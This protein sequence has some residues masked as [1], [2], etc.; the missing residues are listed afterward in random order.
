MA[1]TGADGQFSL[2]SVEPGEY[3]LVTAM[4]L[5]REPASRPVTL[6]EGQALDV[7][8][9]PVRPRP[10]IPGTIGAELVPDDDG[11]LLIVGVMPG[12]PA[13][14]AGLLEGDVLLSVDGAP[15]TG[16]KQAMLRLNG[17]PST[18]VVLTVRREGTE[19]SI[20][21]VRAP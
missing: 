4:G 12:S 14:K 1:I 18:S 16:P 20:S 2:E 15:V 6:A 5:D 17:A 7:G 3:T 9:I 8:E 11:Q 19:Q 13:E 10:L 21:V